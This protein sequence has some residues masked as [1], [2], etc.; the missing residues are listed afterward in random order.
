MMKEAVH[1]VLTDAAAKGGALLVG[2][3]QL[4]LL[5]GRFAERLIFFD[6]ADLLVLCS[7]IIRPQLNSHLPPVMWHAGGL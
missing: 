1:H 5:H 6:A 4:L 3:G 2:S 7:F